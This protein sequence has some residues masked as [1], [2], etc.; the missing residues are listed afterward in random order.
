VS[1]AQ[2]QSTSYYSP[3]R[4]ASSSQCESAFEQGEAKVPGRPS[5]HICT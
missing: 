1:G 3:G 5:E 2:L 4:R